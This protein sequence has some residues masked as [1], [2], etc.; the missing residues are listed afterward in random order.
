MY[1]YKP[2]I[3]NLISYSSFE[4]GTNQIN[5]M[6]IYRYPTR[7]NKISKSSITPNKNNI[8]RYYNEYKK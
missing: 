4:R 3:R 1:R 6:N 8:N 2:I 7:N 5:Q